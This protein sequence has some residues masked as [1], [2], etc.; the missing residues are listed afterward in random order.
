VETGE[1]TRSPE[2]RCLPASSNEPGEAIVKVDTRPGSGARFEGYTDEAS[3]QSK[4]ARDVFEAEDIWFR[5]GD[6]MRRDDHGFF[7]FVDRV[8]DSFRWKGENVSTL[9]V[10][11]TIMEFPGIVMANVYGVTVPGTE[12]RAGMAALAI[13]DNFELGGF[14]VHLSKQLAHYA[15]PLFLRITQR[16]DVTATFK[17]IKAQLMS[18]GFDPSLVAQPLYFHDAARGSYIPLDERL[19]RAIRS[20]QMRL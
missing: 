1:L 11:Q 3:A 17:P 20:G 10:A 12:G 16:I 15:I 8:G 18:E 2:G 5:S 9:E 13:E 6:L 4:L 19:Y 14:H 7:Y